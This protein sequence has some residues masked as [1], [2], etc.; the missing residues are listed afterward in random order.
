VA[1]AQTLTNK[2][3][4]RLTFTMSTAHHMLLLLLLLL[5]LQWR[6]LETLMD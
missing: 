2:E 6:L 5:L 1:R 3:Y 4:Q